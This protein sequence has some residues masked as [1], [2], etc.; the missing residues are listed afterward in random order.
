MKKDVKKIAVLLF[1]GIAGLVFLVGRKKGDISYI[2]SDSEIAAEGVEIASGS[3]IK[4]DV[5][6]GSETGPASASSITV[7]ESVASPSTIYV[8]VCGCVKSEGVYE[9][10][11]GDR[12]DK[13]VKL[14][15]GFRKNADTKLVNLAAPVTDGL[16]IY[17]PEKGESGVTG[18][19]GTENG[20]L[21]L[22]EGTAQISGNGSASAGTGL[23]NINT[24]SSEELQTIS[25]VGPSKAN[26]IIDY[27]NSN[28]GFKKIEDIM[29]IK[30][31]KE[32]LFNKI[33]DKITV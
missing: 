29:N 20:S 24:A 11:E 28:G 5:K 14:A 22:N 27:R 6:E 32:G 16:E 1:I 21:S 3:E 17:V 15:G 9:L 30:G 12:V 25:G 18:N 13:A 2:G 33:K 26:L 8:Y 4:A 23:V 10:S 19:S 7:L 31:I